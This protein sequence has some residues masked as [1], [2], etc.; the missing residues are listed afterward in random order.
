MTIELVWSLV[1]HGFIFSQ[2]GHSNSTGPKIGGLATSDRH[3]AQQRGCCMP[4]TSLMSTSQTSTNKTAGASAFVL[5]E[6]HTFS[7]CRL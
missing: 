2:V 3:S 4:R 6:L 1:Y 5:I 7:S